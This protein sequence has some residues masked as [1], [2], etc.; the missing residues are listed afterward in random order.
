MEEKEDGLHSESGVHISGVAFV[1]GAAARR[2]G[3]EA[4]AQWGRALTPAGG[5]NAFY[6]SGG[7]GSSCA[8]M[9]CQLCS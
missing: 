8:A 7:G 5:V 4:G 9:P 6:G 3:G 1:L 2:C